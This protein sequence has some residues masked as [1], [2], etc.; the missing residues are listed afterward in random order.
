MR[1][2]SLRDVLASP[3]PYVCLLVAAILVGVVFAPLAVAAVVVGGA[4]ASLLVWRFGAVRG[5]WYLVILTLP[6][7]E[8]LSFDIHGT[9]SVYPTDILMV[10]LLVRV[11]ASTG[12]RELWRRSQS[13]RL[14]LLIAALSAAGLYTA[15]NFFW[16][17]ASLY[18]IVM[19]VV[20]FGVARVL[21]TDR[22]EAKRVLAMVALSLVVPVIVGLY[23]ASVP[24]GTELPDWGI[25]YTAYDASGNPSHRVFSTLN[26]P[27]NL[28]HYLTV[29]FALSLGLAVGLKRFWHRVT[30]VVIAGLSVLCNLY[31]YS[32]GGVL[33]MLGAVVA[34][35]VLRR[36]WKLV[37]AVLIVLVI[38]ALMAP[39]AL[40]DKIDRLFSGEALTAAARIVTYQQA[41]MVLQDHPVFGLGWGSI[42]TSLEGA[43]RISRADPVAF[44]AENYFLQ[45]AI[46]LGLVGLALYLAL[47]FFFARNVRALRRTWSSPGAVDPVT[48]AMLAAATAFLVQAQVIPATNISPNSVLWLL[49]A[50]AEALRQPLHSEGLP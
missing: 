9:V 22:S 47:W 15:T 1:P 8:P 5:L 36:S 42:R 21:V 43:Y 37:V 31:T 30:L 2:V 27:L 44:T 13:L 11:V 16:G 38:V 28:S 49:F 14:V 39:P 6:L 40:V 32:A 17:V 18:R 4:A 48:T 3:W 19:L 12:L 50:M 26:H 10:F 24:F 7:K 41:F 29:G 34:L 45:R 23:Q 20:L 46:A 33:G 35:T 25:A